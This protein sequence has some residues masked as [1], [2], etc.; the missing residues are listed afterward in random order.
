MISEKYG[1]AGLLIKPFYD[2]HMQ[3]MVSLIGRISFKV[4]VCPVSRIE[5][6]QMPLQL[7]HTALVKSEGVFIAGDVMIIIET[8]KGVPETVQY[9]RRGAAGIFSVPETA[10]HRVKV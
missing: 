2:L 4:I 7:R 5:I 6:P 9:P 8:V 1:V 10:V 3:R